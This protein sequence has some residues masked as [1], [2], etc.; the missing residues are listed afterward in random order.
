[1]HLVT[2]SYF[3]EFQNEFTPPYSN[4]KNFECFANYCIFSQFSSDTVEPSE[5]VYED[6]DP[7]IDGAFIFIDDRAVFSLEELDRLLLETRRDLHFSVVFTQVKSS[8]NWQKKEI[9]SFA[10]SIVDL[11]SDDPVQPHGETLAEF[12]DI[13]QAIFRNIG[14]V[15]GGR[16]DAFAYFISAASDTEAVEIN[17]AFSIGQKS[18]EG[19]GLFANVSFLKT[20]R[21]VLHDYWLSINSSV[22]ATLAT[23]GYAP[24][25]AAPDIVNAYVATVHARD[26]IDT[27]L[28][29]ADGTVRKKLFEE[30][31][32]DFLGVDAEVNSEISA[33][34]S[35]EGKRDRFGIMNN[36]VTIVASDVRVAGQDI[37]V[38][39]FQIVN[40]CQTSN[41]LI[42][43]DEKIARGVSLMVKLIQADEPNVIDD[44]VRATN[45]QSKVEDAQFVSTMSF[46]KKLELYFRARGEDEANRLY[47]ERRK[48]QYGPE[49]IAA[50]RVFDVRETARCFA[51]ADLMRPDIASRYP[52]R[53][54]SELLSDVYDPRNNEEAYYVSCYSL[55]RLKLLI[56]N[57]R[58]DPKYSK[59]RWHILSAAAQYC[60]ET[61][62]AA[63]YRGKYEAMYA[64]F[65]ENE[66][67]KFDE[68]ERLVKA[69]IPEP[70][71]SRDVLKSQ[72]LLA[73]TLQNVATLIAARKA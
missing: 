17:A 44:I 72:P 34:L 5:L 28:K 6:T 1:M 20:H 19:T 62:K 11:L 35:D 42:A 7:G 67:S 33:T 12:R 16:P 63:G 23:V 36:G 46:L 31:V 61:F 8:V 52:N 50:V 29:T 4:S 70:D 48:G 54:T 60:G 27:V 53:L 39:D 9:D 37:Y 71:I 41:M 14:R 21:E 13:F 43:E 73:E 56:S 55:Y 18:L 25:P 30:N 68:L 15:K 58:L 22:E 49:N 32:R 47:F 59:L 57:K 3:A 38:R 26:F 66:G 64:L 65:S 10:A 24:F 45:R 40:G 69:G 2:R 51:A